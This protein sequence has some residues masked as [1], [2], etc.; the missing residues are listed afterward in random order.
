MTRFA[1]LILAFGLPL[2]ACDAKTPNETPPAPVTDT[3]PA[4]PATTPKEAPAAPK[5]A[6]ETPPEANSTPPDETIEEL[7]DVEEPTGEAAAGQAPVQVAQAP[8]ANEPFQEGKDYIRFPAAQPTSSPPD[9]VEVAE[10]FMYSCPHCFAFEPELA[11]WVSKKPANVNFIRLPVNFNPTASL[12]MRAYYAAETLGVLE[13]I[14]QPLFD[15]IH[16]RKNPMADPDSI[17]KFF[18]AHG[19]EEK[20]IK[21]AMS[22]FAIDARVRKTEALLRRYQISSV[23]TLII[24]GK[25]RTDVGMA[26][27]TPRVFEVV[28]YLIHKEQTEGAGAAPQT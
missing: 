16:L 25:Y 28:E 6:A 19:V 22:S 18:V 2:A 17:I 24:N 26:G 7:A 8:A 27:G 13:K 5:P 23:P 3:A 14:H 11:K 4:A 20:A 12:H 10:A 1:C 21:D 9:Q 15:E